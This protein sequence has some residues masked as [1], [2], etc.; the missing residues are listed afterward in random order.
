MGV[1]ISEPSPEVS[2]LKI[3]PFALLS[4]SR[5]ESILFDEVRMVHFFMLRSTLL[6]L[7]FFLILSEE[8]AAQE[9]DG[10]STED[11]GEDNQ[12]QYCGHNKLSVGEEIVNS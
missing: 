2:G 1:L 5:N 3:K 8:A 9:A 4:F 7:V 11:G 10:G 6:W 12:A